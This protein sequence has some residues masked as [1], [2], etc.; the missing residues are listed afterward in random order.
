MSKGARSVDKAKSVAALG[1]FDGVH[2]GHQELLRQAVSLADTIG[3]TPM[4]V[5][6]D[7]HP[8]ALLRP[9]AAPKLLQ[10]LSSRVAKLHQYGALRV[11]VIPFTPDFA[12]LD[13]VD[14]LTSI[15]D[16]QAK[17]AGIVVGVDFRFGRGRSGDARTIQAFAEERGIA[18]RVVDEVTLNGTAVRSTAVRTALGETDLETV[19][20]L[21]GRDWSLTGKVVRGKQLG[22]QLGWPTANVEHGHDI[23]M[24]APGVYAGWAVGE[25]G[26]RMAAISIGTNPTVAAGNPVTFEAYLLDFDGD[27][28]DAELTVGVTHHIR[29]MEKFATLD[30]LKARIAEDVDS[31]RRV[32]TSTLWENVSEHG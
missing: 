2:L 13:P 23:A 14:F 10:T 20:A 21:L 9:D 1:I 17:V 3:A 4:A 22:R 12:A 27:L 6:F 32:M 11:D 16:G 18:V 26:R 8:Q 25:F 29:G 31:T 30:A 19:K 5:T 28:Y 24:P 15:C 7:P